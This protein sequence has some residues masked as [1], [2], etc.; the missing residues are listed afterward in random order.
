LT[1]SSGTVLALSEF[2][3]AESPADR[4]EH[5][6]ARSMKH[7][8]IL[9]ATLALVGAA[10]GVMA[11]GGSGPGAD[12]SQA[13]EVHGIVVA[14]TGGSGSGLPMLTVDDANLGQ[15]DVALGP[16]WYLQAAEFSAVAGDEIHLLAYAC[17]TCAASA[18]AAWIDNL[19]T[20]ASI[21]LRDE[22]GRPLWTQRQSQRS[23]SG[24]P[25][26]G[27]GTGGQNGD[28]QGG[29]TGDGSGGDIGGGSGGGSGSGQPGGSGSGTGSGPGN[30]SGLDMSLIDTVTGSVI[31]FTGHAGS[32]QP[33][34][35]LDVDGETYEI[36]VSPYGPIEAS[37]MVIEPGLI[38]TIVFAPTDCE[39]DPHLVAISILDDATGFLVQL[40]DPETG[41]PMTNGGG[42]NRP[43]W[44]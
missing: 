36:T 26:Q 29:G 35:T 43:N 11:A 28:G 3:G 30:G 32:G 19:T 41:F 44:P 2:A 31:D 14:M 12:P 24:R 20:G 15:V 13:F 37:G 5:K 10:S 39:E 16:V 40:R 33:I 21:D 38:L 27:N 17:P 1:P 7:S 34:V 23:G 42:H 25:G 22:D 6:E 9:I 18:V 4:I 8:I